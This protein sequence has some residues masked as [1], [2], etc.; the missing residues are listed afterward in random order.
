M[1]FLNNDG[2]YETVTLRQNSSK[3][4]IDGSLH[5]T[6]F[7]TVEIIGS[8]DK[9]YMR[10]DGR[11]RYDEF[12]IKF[13]DGTK[14]IARRSN[15]NCGTVKN[16]N[17]PNVCHRGFIGQGKMRSW[18]NRETTPEYVLWHAMLNR[19]YGEKFL[20]ISP[21]YRGCKV[22]ERWHNFQNFCKDIETIK[23]YDDWVDSLKGTK[24]Q[25]DKDIKIEGNKLY[26]KETC[27]FV[28]RLENMQQLEPT[29][30]G[31]LYKA[32]NLSTG[33]IILFKNQLHFAKAHSLSQGNIWACLNG[34]YKTTKG[35]KFSIQEH[36]QPQT[37]EAV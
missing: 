2:E 3:T 36:K 1:T 37:E 21:T 27:L 4:L 22:V 34:T 30:T 31:H 12:L 13:Q 16:L 18:V 8:V 29:I 11:R 26:S 14:T 23:G 5:E 7:G 24:Y 33:E 9:V 25:L 35:W 10:T 15:I 17:Y 19:C 20:D 32:E 28:S 6:N